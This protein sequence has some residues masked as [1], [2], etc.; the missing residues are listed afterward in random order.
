[1]RQHDRGWRAID[2]G[3]A[4]HGSMQRLDVALAHRLG[5]RSGETRRRTDRQ[6]GADLHAAEPTP[7]RA[8]GMRRRLGSADAII[9]DVKRIDAAD[10]RERRSEARPAEGFLRRYD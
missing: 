3:G 9:D 4:G 6:H 2:P 7:R 5:E 8:N 1:M 10:A